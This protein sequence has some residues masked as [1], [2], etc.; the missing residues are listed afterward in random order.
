MIGFAKRAGKIVYG[1]DGL[2]KARGI[3]LLAVSASASEN[4]AGE[5][6]FLAK[7]LGVTLVS[8]DGLQDKL[9]SNI[10]AL[11]VTDANMAKAIADYV[12]GGADGY[13]TVYE[14]RR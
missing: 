13:N 14:L 12:N 8:A 1:I 7:K 2:R 6:L 9:G 3:K 5:M 10:K 11:G 4:L